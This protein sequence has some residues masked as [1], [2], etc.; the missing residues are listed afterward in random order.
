MKVLGLCFLINDNINHEELWYNWLKNVDKNKYKIYI[1]YKN[2]IK[3]KYFEEY[4]LDNCIETKYGKYSVNL[5]QNL[6]MK[7]GLDICSHFIFLSGSCIPL[8]SFISIYD[9]LSINNSYF[10]KSPDRQCFP[11][12]NDVLNHL[13]KKYIKKANTNSIICNNHAKKII[14]NEHFATE[15]FKNIVSADEHIHITILYYLNLEDELIV[16]PNTCYSGATTFTAWEDMADFKAYKDSIKQNSYTYIHI[17]KEE[18]DDLINGKCL[19]G[20]KFKPEC[21]VIKN[22]IPSVFNVEIDQQLS[23]YLTERLSME[24]E[25]VPM[26]K[27]SVPMEKES[28]PME[29]VSVSM[30][31]VSVV[32]PTYNRFKYLMN[33]IQSVKEQTHANIEIIVVNDCS[34][35]TEYYQY[36]WE[37]NGIRIIHLPENSKTKF[38]FACPGG[39]QR[40]FGIKEATGEYIAFCDDDD[41]WFPQKLELQLKAMKENDC[42]MSCTEGLMGRGI[43]DNKKTYKKYNKEYW[44]GVLKNI[45]KKRGS[46]LLDNGFPTVWTPEFFKVHNCAICSSMM[47]KKEVIDKVG[48][49]VI[50]RSNED[51]EYWRRAVKYTTCAYVDEPCMYYDSGH[52][53]GQNY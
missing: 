33:T 2:D 10:N 48:E 45:Y 40:N 35:D 23:Q 1:H 31:K 39:Y 42:K 46:S 6:M 3:L 37:E 24:K 8:K 32:I 18:I 5:A 36:N 27:E 19:F 30:E 21:K 52:G 16:T 53:D 28:V 7:Q 43:Y 12:C 15:Y 49:F 4:K 20:R 47:I 9:Q 13:E 11:R 50:A 38:G 25:S 22:K 41:I 26:E 17:C 34:T 14:K 44:F 51:Y 29:K